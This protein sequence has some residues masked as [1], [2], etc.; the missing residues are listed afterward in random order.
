MKKILFVTSIMLVTA[1]VTLAQNNSAP[2]YFLEN[3][4]STDFPGAKN[5]SF[6]VEKELS[7]VSFTLGN[8]KLNA[9]YDETN[10]L[11]GT[12]K[13]ETFADL[14]D[15]AKYEI[16]KKYAGYTVVDVIKFDDIENESVELSSYGSSL[17]E[18]DNYFVELKNDDK[19]IVVKVDLSGGVDYI[20][21]MK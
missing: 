20:R 19:A 4:F 6:T 18:A 10:E 13:K 12:T 15:N 5:V 7:K 16:I 1:T 8:E 3:Q 17:N 9:Y 2:S 14:P 11:L 21:D